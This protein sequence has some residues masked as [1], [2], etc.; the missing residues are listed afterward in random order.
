MARMPNFIS[1][2]Y[3]LDVEVRYAN[4]NDKVLYVFQRSGLTEF[5][6]SMLGL[7]LKWS[8]GWGSNGVVVGAQARLAD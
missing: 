3:L 2:I 4:L 6:I 8:S 1:C 5:S 7:L